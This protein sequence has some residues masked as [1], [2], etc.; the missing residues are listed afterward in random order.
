[1]CGEMDRPDLRDSWEPLVLDQ[2]IDE[3]V[4]EDPPAH[5][6]VEVTS[7]FAIGGEEGLAIELEGSPALLSHTLQEVESTNTKDSSRQ[8]GKHRERG[9]LESIISKHAFLPEEGS[10]APL[11]DIKLACLI[12]PSS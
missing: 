2:F 11:T 4:L 6:F 7:Y 3:A 5:A 10:D 9:G 8:H 1:M 12:S